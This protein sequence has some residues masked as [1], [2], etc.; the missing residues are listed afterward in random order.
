[1]MGIRKIIT[2]I[3][4]ERNLK[5]LYDQFHK[6]ELSSVEKGL[7]YFCRGYKQYV[8]G[9]FSRGD[10]SIVRGRYYKALANLEVAAKSGAECSMNITSNLGRRVL[11]EEEKQDIHE[12]LL[13][14]GMRIT[15]QYSNIPLSLMDRLEEDLNRRTESKEITSFA[16]VPAGAVPSSE[17][18]I[19]DMNIGNPIV[20]YTDRNACGSRNQTS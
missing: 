18:K 15:Q 9:N 17:L 13:K 14:T 5:K 1:M 16:I 12:F 10:D 2:K 8:A 7:Y 4:V 6:R 11:D 20:I 3:R 19:L